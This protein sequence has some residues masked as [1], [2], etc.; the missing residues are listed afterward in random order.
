MDDQVRRTLFLRTLDDVEARLRSH[1]A[2]EV[3]YLSALLRKLLLDGG[4]SLIDQVNKPYR[5]KIRFTIA[6]PDTPYARLALSRN[7]EFFSIADGIDPDAKFPNAKVVSRTRDQF[8]QTPVLYVRGQPCSIRDL[9]LFEANI[10]GAVHAGSPQTDKEKAIAS[11]Q[12]FYSLGGLPLALRQMLSIAK[13]V[14]VS[15][16]P[17]RDAVRRDLDVPK[18]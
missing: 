5:F 14:L 8:F 9:I 7:P 3:L 1:D 15:V 16:S 10:M 13:I 18:P 17:L 11:I 6:D 4:I 2:Y 12:Q